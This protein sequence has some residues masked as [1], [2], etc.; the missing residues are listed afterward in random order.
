MRGFEDHR[1]QN[2][3]SSHGHHRPVSWEGTA[4]RQHPELTDQTLRRHVSN[5]TSLLLDC[6][7]ALPA[8]QE[9]KTVPAPELT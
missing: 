5:P 4:Q 2:G 7:I 6:A 8:L 9:E 1:T 3:T